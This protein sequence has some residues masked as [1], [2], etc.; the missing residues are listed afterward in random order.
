M[1]CKPF[2]VG[3]GARHNGNTSGPIAQVSGNGFKQIV[4]CATAQEP[5]LA[6]IRAEEKKM[7]F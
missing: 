1:L 7:G 6:D 4:G 3:D 2:Y 5:E